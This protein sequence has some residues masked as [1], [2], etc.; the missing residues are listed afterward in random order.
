MLTEKC[1]ILAVDDDEDILLSL[2]LLLKNKVSRVDTET[3]PL[4]ITNLIKKQSYDLILLDMNFTR[5]TSSGQEGFDLLQ[6]ILD[7]QPQSVIIFLTAYGDVEKAIKALKAGAVDFIL[8]PWQ[9]EKLWATIS[10]ALELSL[11]RKENEIYKQ[12]QEMLQSDINQS[13]HSIVGNSTAIQNTFSIIRKAGPTQ[14]NILITGENGTGKELV[15]RALHNCSHRS[16]SVFLTVDLGTIPENL[17][18]S[19]LFGYARG[20]FT[21]ADKD[22]MGRFEAASGGTLFLDEIGNLNLSQQ[23]KL[24]TAIEKREITRVGSNRAIP[25][26][27]RI[28]CA[29]NIPLSNLLLQNQFRQDLLYRINTVEINLPP[30]RE[31]IDDIPLLAVYFLE[32]FRNKYGKPNMVMDDSALKHLQTYNWPGNIRELQHSVERAIILSDDPVLSKKDFLF[33]L[34][35]PENNS[36]NTEF[37]TLEEIEK[38]AVIDTLAKH[39]GNISYAAKDLGITRASLYRRMEKYGL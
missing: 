19:E 4:K 17:F 5:D 35:K 14:A 29:T 3:N 37:K 39:N 20:A 33:L 16:D 27:L 8:K 12:R 22:K 15:A 1:S 26:D 31:R 23:A 34:K 13:F 38:H 10:S 11:S 9:N 25:V 21:G 2:K 28:I 36:D 32:K 6:K 30:L 24:L 18:E 7:I